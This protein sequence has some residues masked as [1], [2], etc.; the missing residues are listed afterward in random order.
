MVAEIKSAFE[1]N[2]KYVSWM[3]SE[4]KNAAKEKVRSCWPVAF[5]GLRVGGGKQHCHLV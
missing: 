1:E 5:D 4:T 3:D 2:L